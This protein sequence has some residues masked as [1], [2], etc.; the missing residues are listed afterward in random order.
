LTNHDSDALR[1]ERLEVS[2]PVASQPERGVWST[3]QNGRRGL[4]A[5]PG[6]FP[7]HQIPPKP[8]YRIREWYALV[9]LP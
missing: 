3:G 6:T 1:E 9:S 7:T 4:I 8:E 5:E 2:E